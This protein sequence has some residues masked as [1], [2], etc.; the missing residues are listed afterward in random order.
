V[1]QPIGLHIAQYG[2]REQS[3]RAHR[4]IGLL[5]LAGEAGRNI[6]GA[7]DAG[8]A[9]LAVGDQH[10]VAQPRADRRGGVADM[11][12]ERAETQTRLLLVRASA[13]GKQIFDC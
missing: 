13:H 2:N 3:R 6:A 1:R 7:P 4:P 8:A 12:H 11:D 5:E 9:A 10:R